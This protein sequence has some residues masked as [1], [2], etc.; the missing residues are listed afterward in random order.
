MSLGKRV[1][2]RD[3]PVLG[4][5]VSRQEVRPGGVQ[6]WQCL[7]DSKLCHSAAQLVGDGKK[8]HDFGLLLLAVLTLRFV[9]E[10]LVALG[11][12]DNGQKATPPPP[13]AAQIAQSCRPEPPDLTL[14]ALQV[15]GTRPSYL[16][17]MRPQAKGDKVTEPTPRRKRTGCGERDL[18]DG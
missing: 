15:S 4:L 3:K 9:L 7:T 2:L 5:G 12:R 16:L 10:P 13:R 8:V 1:L 6:S 17:V 11:A 18:G 14:M